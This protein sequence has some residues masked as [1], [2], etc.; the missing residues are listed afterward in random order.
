MRAA[1]PLIQI[2]HCQIGWI[3]VTNLWNQEKGD[4]G[5]A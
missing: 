4:E 5:I 3:K 1:Q 2:K